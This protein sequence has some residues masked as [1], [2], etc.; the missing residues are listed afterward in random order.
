MGGGGLPPQ[1]RKIFK[2]KIIKR[3]EGFS[4]KVRFFFTFL[5]SSLNPQNYEL[6]PQIPKKLL[7]VLPSS[8]KIFSHSPQIRK[9]PR[10]STDYFITFPRLDNMTGRSYVYHNKGIVNSLQ[11][12]SKVYA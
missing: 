6:A 8:L 10:G 1:K 5:Q 12:G 11:S 9:T 2:K 7:P 3:N 4:F